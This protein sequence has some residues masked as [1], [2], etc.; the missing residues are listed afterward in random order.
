M[1]SYDFTERAYSK[2]E[3]K[4]GMHKRFVKYRTQTESKEVKMRNTNDENKVL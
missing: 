4:V 2:M 3:I 1:L